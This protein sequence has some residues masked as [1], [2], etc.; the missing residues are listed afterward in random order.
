[1]EALGYFRISLREKSITN[2]AHNSAAT[3]AARR[4]SQ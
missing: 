3:A 1:L 4:T 2:A